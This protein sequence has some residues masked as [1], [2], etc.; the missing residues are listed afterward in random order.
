MLVPCCL[1]T[2]NAILTL[3][4]CKQLGKM[5]FMGHPK[6]ILLEMPNNKKLL[7]QAYVE[8]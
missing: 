5:D 7:D 4:Q 8:P 6:T 3:A 2:D 1:E